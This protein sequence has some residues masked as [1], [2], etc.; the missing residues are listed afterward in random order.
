VKP[1][2]GR[3]VLCFTERS[4]IARSKSMQAVGS[5]RV[6]ASAP[7][8]GSIGARTD[9]KKLAQRKGERKEVSERVETMIQMD[10]NDNGVIHERRNPN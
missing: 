9:K 5:L 4:R 7:Q 10:S 8:S 3:S 1:A 2:C 6:A